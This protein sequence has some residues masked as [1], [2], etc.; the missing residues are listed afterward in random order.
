M[1]SW[2]PARG[3]R[4]SLR[5]LFLAV[6]LI[7]IFIGLAIQHARDRRAAIQAIDDL[8]GSYGVYL[9]GPQ[10]LRDLSGDEKYFYDAGRVTLGSTAAY[11]RSDR[12]ATDD[13]MA[14]VVTHLSVFCHLGH[15]DLTGSKISDVGVRPLRRLSRLKVLDL[16]ATDISD[17]GLAELQALRESNLVQTK[18]TQQGIDELR[19]ALP[20]CTI[21]Y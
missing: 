16:N 17:G 15:L 5:A 4:F 3:P 8:G 12:Q 1:T 19:Q 13:D 9:L 2:L 6:T 10:W 7:G 18:V 21:N 14:R 11:Y 20:N